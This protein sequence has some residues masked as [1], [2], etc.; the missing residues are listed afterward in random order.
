VKFFKKSSIGYGR[1]VSAQ[2]KLGLKE[3][4]LLQNVKTRWNSEFY[5]IERIYDM[6]DAL[7]LVLHIFPQL[8]LLDRDDWVT[9]EELID[10]LAPIESA[11]RMLCGSSYST[12]SSVIPIILN[13]SEKITKMNFKSQ[14]ILKFRA[15]VVKNIKERFDKKET[16][17]LLNISTLLDPRYKKG[18]L[19]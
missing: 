1:L 16:D 14:N 12:I 3:L 19:F 9:I 7:R 8:P 15:C 5:M 4:K 2:R 13:I 6:R 11:T 10:I 17:K 18:I